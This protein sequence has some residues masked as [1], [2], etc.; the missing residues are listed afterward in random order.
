MSVDSILSRC[1]L[2]SETSPSKYKARCPAHD[3]RTPSLSIRETDDG[4]VLIHCFAGCEVE[5][6]LAA[7]GMTFTD[8][9]PDSLS[10]DLPSKAKKYRLTARDALETLD[11]ESLVVAVIGSDFL[12]RREIDE[13]TWARL[14][15]A[16]QRINSTRAEYSPTRIKR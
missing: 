7:L 5:D 6:V 4:R 13:P 8:V 16:V 1:E 3:D 2:V 12:D 11:H 14:A 10:L 9:M 15:S